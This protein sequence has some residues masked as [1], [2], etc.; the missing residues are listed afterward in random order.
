MEKI[1]IKVSF[2]IYN[3]NEVVDINSTLEQN[4]YGIIELP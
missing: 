3:G 1:R 2:Y 4:F